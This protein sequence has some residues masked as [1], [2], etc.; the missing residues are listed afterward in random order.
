MA[1]K[2]R[3]LSSQSNRKTD[4]YYFMA[5]REAIRIEMFGSPVLKTRKERIAKERC[6]FNDECPFYLRPVRT[7]A[8]RMLR[9]TYCCGDPSKCEILT[10]YICDNSIPENMLPDGTIDT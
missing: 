4:F 8:I 6:R 5:D 3:N 1:R 9:E 2:M 7:T 10:S